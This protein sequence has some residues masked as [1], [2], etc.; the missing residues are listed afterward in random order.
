MMKNDLT[1]SEEAK[2]EDTKFLQDLDKNC[3]AKTKEWDERCKTRQEELLAL[4]ETIKILNDDDAMELFKKT[5]PSP[6]LL[7]VRQNLANAQHNALD[8]LKKAQRGADPR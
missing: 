8:A 1:D 2:I 5:L 6:S 3:A 4:A 7:Q